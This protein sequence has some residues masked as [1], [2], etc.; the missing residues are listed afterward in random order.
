[1][2]QV[3][4][5]TSGP[6]SKGTTARLAVSYS[7]TVTASFAHLYAGHAD[8][9]A[10]AVADVQLEQHGG[11]G[12]DGGRVGQRPGVEGP[13]ARN[14]PHQVGRDAGGLGVVGADQDVALHAVVEV[15]ELLGRQ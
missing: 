12:L 14:Q 15:P 5:V 9:G 2:P 8:G 13:A 10:G 4:I 3:Y 11:E 1:M 6:G 7:R